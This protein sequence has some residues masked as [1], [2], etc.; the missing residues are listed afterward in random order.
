MV[1]S[2]VGSIAEEGARYV[3]A[4]TKVAGY[5]CVEVPEEPPSDTDTDKRY[6]T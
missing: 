3:V 5:V 4:Q 6:R 2:R 1:S